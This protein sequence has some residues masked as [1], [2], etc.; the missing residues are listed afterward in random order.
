MKTPRLLK[1]FG[2]LIV[3]VL[4]SFA[5]AFSLG[6]MLPR[7][8][9]AVTSAVIP[10]ETQQV[11]DAVRDPGVQATWRSDLDSAERMM[12]REGHESWLQ[13]GDRGDWPVELI[14][15]D[16]PHRLVTQT[17]APDEGY[18][19]TWTFELESLEG[20]ATR[21][22]LRESGFIEQPLF[23]FLARFVVGLHAP[24]ETWLRDLGQHF[25]ASVN[26]RR[27]A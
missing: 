16:P 12:D 23:R 21:V 27:G 14:E 26:P 3:A 7:Q 13:H 22:T 24:H 17:T 4:A 2:L 1:L 19:G 6:M 25:G 18:G 5:L 9:L 10:A 20:G 15:S 11:W 8:H